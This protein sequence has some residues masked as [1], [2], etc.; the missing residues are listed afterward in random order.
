MKLMVR[1]F[2][3]EEKP[4]DRDPSQNTFVQFLQNAGLYDKYEVSKDNIQDVIDVLNGHV[5]INVFCKECGESRVFSMEK[6]LFPFEVADGNLEMRGLGAELASNQNVQKLCATPRP[7]ETLIE[8]EW[9]W[10]NWQTQDFTRMMVFQYRCAMDSSHFTDFVVRANGNTLLKIGQCPSIADL[11][12]PELDEYKK[13]LTNEN[14]REFGRAVG[15]YASGI[16]AGSYVYLR[17]IFERLLMQAKEKAGDA[18]DTDAFNKAHVDEKI[19]MLRGYLPESLTENPALYGILSKGIHE[20]SEEDCISYFP[21]V[22]ECIYMILNEWEDMRKK[23]EH[24]EAISSALSK[25]AT[26]IPK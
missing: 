9:Y 14:R 22:K 1:A 21:V 12:F 17:R 16:G 6:V 8:H 26:N 2:D 7:G 23:A 5:R 3:Q 4:Y 18:I 19:K 13:V 25:I 11:T 24:Q 20:L 10:T 15:L